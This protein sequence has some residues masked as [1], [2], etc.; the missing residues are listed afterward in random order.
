MK[1]AEGDDGLTPLFNTNLD[2]LREVGTFVGALSNGERPELDEEALQRVRLFGN[3]LQ[4]AVDVTVAYEK[5]LQ[6]AET[7]FREG[8][9]EM[10]EVLGGTALIAGIADS[11]NGASEAHTIFANEEL[12][13]VVNASDKVEADVEVN[14]NFTES[15]MV[16]S[17]GDVQSVD[18]D[19]VEEDPVL[20]TLNNEGQFIHSALNGSNKLVLTRSDFNAAGFEEIKHRKQSAQNQAFKAGMDQLLDAGVVVRVA[21]GKYTLKENEE[22]ARESLDQ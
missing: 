22:A 2:V 21:R 7:S 8:I 1:N 14:H 17:K 4:G 20:S 5:K 12:E 11:P 18:S 6:E 3:F 16:S 10:A 9:T 15:E 19:S 13:T